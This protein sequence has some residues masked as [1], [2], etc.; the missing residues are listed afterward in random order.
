MSLFG[1]VA[2][3]ALVVGLA[4]ACNKPDPEPAPAASA[5]ASATASAP[6]SV[7]ASAGEAPPR[8][9]PPPPPPPKQHEDPRQVLA[10]IQG[11]LER[12]AAGEKV[13]KWP[14]GGEPHPFEGLVEAYQAVLA[15]ETSAADKL[16]AV[17]KEARS[18]L[19][20]RLRAAE[21][22]LDKPK[23]GDAA[24]YARK[25]SAIAAAKA[26]G[27]EGT[28]IRLV[29]TMRLV[30]AALVLASAEDYRNAEYDLFKRSDAYTR[31]ERERFREGDWLRLPCRTLLGRRSLVEAAAK[32]L[33]KAAGPLLSCPTPRGKE[34]DFDLMERFVKDPGAVVAEVLPEATEAPKKEEPAAPEPTAPPE[35]WDLRAAILFMGEK[36]DAASKPLEAAAK[37]STVGK[38]D[39][40][41]FLHA[42]RP[43]SAARDE[44]IKKLL[45]EVEKASVAAAKKNDDTFLLED[46]SIDRRVYDGT[47][48]S[49]LG[50]VRVASASGAANTASAFYAIPCAVLLARPKLLES[51]TPLFGGNRDN[52]LPRSG[53]AWGRGFVRGFPDREL[54]AYTQA[55]EEADG[56]FYVNHGGSLRFGLAAA[57][58]AKEEAMR[59]D[60]KSLLRIPTP[61]TT[62]PYET[63]S[64]M[65]PE[66]RAMYGRLKRLAEDLRTKLV[67]HD[68]TR[69]LDEKQANEAAHVGLFQVVWGAACGDAAPPRSLRKLVVDGAK[70]EE[71]RAFLQ[72][73]EHEKAVLEP[74]RACAKHTGMDPLVH[75]AVLNAAALP[76]LWEMK[77][78]PAR[79][80]ELD[81]VVDPNAPNHFG[82]TPLMAAAQHDRLDAARRLLKRGAVVQRATFQPYEPKLA[83]DARTPLM[84]A[85]ARGSLPM[86][87]LLLDAG[88][89]KYAADT[90][91]RI[92]LHYLLGHGPVRPN[93]N[94]SPAD[95]AEA[96][97][98][99][100]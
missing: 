72:A 80:E 42:L 35:P 61:P 5:T 70:P 53:C 27:P 63:W 2:A 21:L 88:G 4:S 28:M 87:R 57:L 37:K 67:A 16:A 39:H 60:P 36:P 78:D 43:Q 1:R 47:D 85:A 3:W 13:A 20:G 86:I 29:A 31:T 84:Y 98:L 56:H 83:H 52:F 77:V 64:Y 69:G 12:L 7:A 66:S 33:D 74:F 68:K 51:T 26:E 41:L 25:V 71:I 73:S 94:L 55:S 6:A 11:N 48:E 99:L 19:E 32:R 97:K 38:L 34:R 24:D 54:E 81:L 91:G 89:D 17:A 44:N 100:F 95:L 23:P 62:W 75:M 90:K 30:D 58:K 79:A 14:A 96:A 9:A 22:S 8:P 82:K 76:I 50:I 92:P 46:A 40:A 93:P 49:L 65:T 10:H 15:G 45:G 59:I 18:Q